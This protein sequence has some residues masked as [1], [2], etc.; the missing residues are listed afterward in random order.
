MM[1]SGSEPCSSVDTALLEHIVNKLAEA[2]SIVDDELE[3]STARHVSVVVDTGAV[4]ECDGDLATKW[5]DVHLIDSCAVDVDAVDECT[6]SVE[7]N[8]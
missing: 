3:A 4:S 1:R 2:A 7:H 6:S 8:D 5:V